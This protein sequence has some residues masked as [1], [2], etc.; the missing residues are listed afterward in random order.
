MA[1][2]T[3]REKPRKAENR[4]RRAILGHQND[5]LA[6]PGGVEKIYCKCSAG[7][8]NVRIVKSETRLGNADFLTLV[9]HGR[10]F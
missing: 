6:Q 4:L 10:T 3:S 9:F 2:T 7:H 1:L 5:F 8:Y